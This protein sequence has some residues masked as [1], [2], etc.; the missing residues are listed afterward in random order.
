VVFV[1]IEYKR[2]FIIHRIEWVYARLFFFISKSFYRIA[3]AAVMDI[4]RRRCNY[5]VYR[6]GRHLFH[7]FQCISADYAV[8]KISYHLFDLEYIIVNIPPAIITA[9][10]KKKAILLILS[11]IIFALFLNIFII[12]LGW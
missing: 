7:S 12:L 1:A 4:I 10:S 9:I 5:Q 11:N 2:L 6:P 3:V 8:K